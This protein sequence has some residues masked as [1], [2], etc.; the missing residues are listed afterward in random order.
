MIKN[1]EQI[2]SGLQIPKSSNSNR[3]LLKPVSQAF[4]NR[5]SLSQSALLIVALAR[6]NPIK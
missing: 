2:S 6:G 1:Q 4:E 5:F 3:G